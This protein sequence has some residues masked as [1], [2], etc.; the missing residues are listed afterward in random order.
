MQKQPQADQLDDDLQALLDE[1][2]RTMAAFTADHR[3][4]N[5]Y[6]VMRQDLEMPPGKF[7]ALAAHAAQKSLKVAEKAMPGTQA[8]YEGS[9][10]G[11]KLLMG[12]K[13]LHQLIRAYRDAKA[14]GLP[15]WLVIERGDVCPPSFD[16]SPVFTCLGI[17]PVYRDEAQCVTKRLSLLR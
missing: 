14:A 10:N 17:G 13:N 1:S 15:C 12:A 9:G 5:M 2:A 8:H 7:G 3:P 16:G 11:T 4:L 6:I